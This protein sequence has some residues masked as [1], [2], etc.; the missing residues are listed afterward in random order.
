M[1]HALSSLDRM[2]YVYEITRTSINLNDNYFN[3][4]GNFANEESG[5]YFEQKP[6]RQMH[7]IN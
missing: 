6:N 4:G 2:D 3:V 5:F 1:W 7:Y